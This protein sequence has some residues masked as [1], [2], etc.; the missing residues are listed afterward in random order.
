[1]SG[2]AVC[3]HAVGQDTARPLRRVIR[4]LTV[5]HAHGT[6]GGLRMS[7]KEMWV[8]YTGTCRF[9]LV[10]SHESLRGDDWPGIWKGRR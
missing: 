4:S 5:F 2:V 6:V 9:L 7:G 10:S 8:S 3:S 1:M